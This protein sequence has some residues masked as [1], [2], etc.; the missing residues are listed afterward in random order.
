V[1]RRALSGGEGRSLNLAFLVPGTVILG[2]LFVVPLAMVLVY[3]FGT[4]NI[5]GLPVLG[6]SLANYREVIQ[7]FY[8][9]VILRTVEYAGA[10]ALICLFL[11]Y[12]VAYFATRY[13]GRFGR[14]II[15]AILFTWLIDYL[16]RIYAWTA[17]LAPHGLVNDV[18]V[19]VGIGRRSLDPSTLAV[20][21]GLV[22][23]YLPLMMLPIYSAL[24]D[25][26]GALIDAG[27]DLYGT[28]TQTF[29]HV[30]LPATRAGVIGGVV[31]T[32]FPALGDFATAQFLGGPNQSM[33]GNVIAQQFTDSGSIPFGAALAVVLLVLLLLGIAA[34]AV[35]SR[36]GLRRSVL[37][38]SENPPATELLPA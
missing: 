11:A 13:A 6:F 33:I 20:V 37:A 23:G 8:V 1:L 2:L 4:T 10:T 24:T 5:V 26:D 16:V 9:P 36:H 38:P 21:A 15:G 27:K 18:L 3:S 29:L 25:L 7:P 32:F 34:L 17:L 19:A 31:L 35:L 28:P 14:L 30:T 12:P 22:Y